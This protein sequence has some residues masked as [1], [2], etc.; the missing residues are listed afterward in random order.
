LRG[1]VQTHVQDY[2]DNGILEPIDPYFGKWDQKDDYFPSAVAA[3]RSKPGQPVLYMP[4]AILP[5][6]LYYRAD[7][8]D[9]AK[10]KPPATYDEFI[11][12]AKAVTRPDRIGYAL[13]GLDYFAV[14]PIEP[15]YRSADVKIIDEAGKVDF[16]S[17][18]AIA[19]TDKWIGMYTRDKSAQPTA[20]NDRYPQL[21][22]LMEQGKAG[23]WIYGTHAHPQLNTALGER[24]QVVPT[25]NVGEKPYMLA[26]PEGLFMLTSCKEKEAAWEFM[27]HMSSGDPV[28]SF[29]QKRGLLPVRKSLAEEPA[30]QNNRFFKVA[31]ANRRVLVDA[32]FLQQELDQLPGQARAVLAAGA[33][34]GDHGGP[35]SR[36]GCEIPARRSL[37]SCPRRRT[38]GGNLS[39][40]RYQRA[41]EQHDDGTGAECAPARARALC[42]GAREAA[43]GTLTLDDLPSTPEIRSI[44]SRRS[45]RSAWSWSCMAAP[46]RVSWPALRQVRASSSRCASR[47]EPSS[48]APA[49]RWRTS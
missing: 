4:T 44:R 7:W 11:A 22:A 1:A 48:S 29:T 12:A 13:R 26:N 49:R 28:R 33:A 18:A 38:H 15:I 46:P 23:M 8:F 27:K 36:A 35:V 6:V 9:E 14:Q 47:A 17:P 2:F 43:L 16:D 40:R 34:P 25:P 31:L 5:Y 24:I 3:M 39:S 21:F 19:I 10:I 20:V 30:Y 37:R 42:R 41:G 45:C 32:A